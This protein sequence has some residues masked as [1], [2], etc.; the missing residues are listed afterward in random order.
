VTRI[1]VS[2]T[3]ALL[4]GAAG[5]GVLAQVHNPDCEVRGSGAFA[6]GDMFEGSGSSFN[7]IYS[8]GWEHTGPGV[9]FT[10]SITDSVHCIVDGGPIAFIDGYGTGTFNGS[11]DYIYYIFAEDRRGPGLPALVLSASRTSPPTL[12][13]DGEATFDPPR[14]LTIPAMLTVTEGH[15]GNGWTRLYIDEVRCDYQGNGTGYDFVRC[16]GRPDL[17]PGAVLTAVAARLRVRTPGESGSDEPVITVQASVAPYVPAFGAPDFYSLTIFDFTGNM[18]Y[19]FA[20]LLMDGEGDIIVK[21]Y[22]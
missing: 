15:P 6:S 11:R 12:F 2:M 10:T 22:E 4:A 16:P 18:I 17:A 20:A 3:M 9:E 13:H 1:F 14:E 8:V 5:N 21:K 19:D 7:D